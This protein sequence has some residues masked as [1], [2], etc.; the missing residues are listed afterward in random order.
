MIKRALSRRGLLRAAPVAVVSAPSLVDHAT[1]G[2]APPSFGFMAES[3]DDLVRRGVTED[4]ARE[5][6]TALR[7]AAQGEIDEGNDMWFRHGMTLAVAAHFDALRSVSPVQRARMYEAKLVER[8]R[9]FD[10]AEA[11]RS[12]ARMLKEYLKRGWSF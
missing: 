5:R 4:A 2:A 6:I 11:G 9:T 1:K 7:R 3:T 10:R 12:L 8:Q